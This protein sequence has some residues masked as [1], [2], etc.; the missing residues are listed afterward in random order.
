MKIINYTS[1]IILSLLMSACV[2][3]PRYDTPGN[4]FHVTH[5]PME[6][7]IGVNL[8]SIQSRLGEL[9]YNSRTY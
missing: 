6:P 4:N 7:Q 3:T 5:A 1:L 9:G 2:V 8:A